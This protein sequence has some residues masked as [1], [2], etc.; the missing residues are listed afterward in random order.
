MA[1]FSKLAKQNDANSFNKIYNTWLN[2]TKKQ[3][4]GYFLVSNGIQSY[5]PLIKSPA[6]NLYIY[7][8][9]HANNNNGD[10]FVSIERIAHDLNVS[11][12]TINNW[13]ALLMDLGLIVRFERAYTSSKTQ[14]LPTS[15][16]IIDTTSDD[17]LSL[18]AVQSLLTEQ[19]GYKEKTHIAIVFLKEKSRITN[20]YEL[21]TRNYGT[22]D[23]KGKDIRIKRSVA[24]VTESSEIDEKKALPDIKYEWSYFDQKD[25]TLDLAL[26]TTIKNISDND[27]L[28]LL[29]DLMDSTKISEFKKAYPKYGT[30]K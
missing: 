27:T 29:K 13:N 3:K 15:D 9:L 6:I 14:L 18:K 12:K 5:L 17:S 20:K 30:Q 23:R 22:T 8:S 7:Y 28:E 25:E 11:P 26:L 24:L 16:F 19:L 10:S 2:Y 21:F 4:T 1:Y